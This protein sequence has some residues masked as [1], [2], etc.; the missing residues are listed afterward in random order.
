MYRNAITRSVFAACAAL[1]MSGV[2]IQ[3]AGSLP[4]PAAPVGAT[5]A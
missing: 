4:L 1:L 5:V 3:Q 2:L